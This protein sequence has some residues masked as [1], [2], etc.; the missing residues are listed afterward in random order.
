MPSHP[1][2][3]AP[4]TARIE[5]DAHR[6]TS[7]LIA[8][9]AAFGI[10]GL[11]PVYW[12]QIPAVPAFEMVS[13]RI[14]WSLLFVALLLTRSR[15]WPEIRSQCTARTLGWSVLSGLAITVNWT[16]FIWAV[17]SGRVVETALGYFLMPLVNLLIGLAFFRER[18][19][20]WQWIAV[21][22]ATA[23]VAVAIGGQSGMPW[24]A[25]GLCLS[26]GAYGAL[27]KQ[28]HLESVPGLFFETLTMAPLALVWL[29][30]L[31]AAGAG[32][33]GSHDLRT[34]CFLAGAGVVTATPLLW[35]S[36]AAR[37]L[38]LSTVG[39]IQY[40][41]P[42][43]SFILGTLIYHEPVTISRLITFAC[44]WLALGIFT[45]EAT[46]GRRARVQGAGSK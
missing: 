26:F 13:H 1:D 11:L 37:R 4:P 6:R 33:F 9:F 20:F 41:S 40:L 32:S 5:S 24:V 14:L 18:L 10:W 22:V 28:S 21:G 38:P 39:F 46:W 44:V 16:L 31:G 23:G 45:F 7:G 3:A 25:I 36:H 34:S 35:F 12:K 29:L 15:S 43:M 8:A 42:G 17:N 30:H 27:R 2:P 19:R